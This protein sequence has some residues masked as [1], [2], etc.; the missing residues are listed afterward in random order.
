MKEVKEVIELP[1]PYDILDEGATQLIS[2]WKNKDSLVVTVSF[3]K[4]TTPIFWGIVISDIFRHIVSMFPSNT[5]K[6]QIAFMMFV[7]ILRE[8]NNPS[9]PLEALSGFNDGD[10]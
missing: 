2:A 4:E 9:D 5:P 7:T 8:L 3:Q 10:A 6:E 1:V